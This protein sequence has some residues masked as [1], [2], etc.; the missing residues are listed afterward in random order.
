MCAALQSDWC[1]ILYPYQH[2]GYLCSPCG[3]INITEW[4]VALNVTGD[5]ANARK[6]I[7]A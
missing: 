5:G 3:L 4:F 1:L 2:V 6:S 7:A